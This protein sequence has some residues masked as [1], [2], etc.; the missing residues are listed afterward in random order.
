PDIVFPSF[1]IVGKLQ[2]AETMQPEL[3]RMFINFAGFL[4]VVSAMEGNPQLDIELVDTKNSR[5]ITTAFIPPQPG[6]PI[7]VQYNF[8]PT[9]LFEGGQIILSSNR[10]LAEQLVGENQTPSKRGKRGW[11]T[12]TQFTLLARPLAV[13]LQ[14]NREILVTNNILDNGSSRAEAEQAVDLILKGVELMKSLDI[15]MEHSDKQL[16]LSFDLQFQGKT[17]TP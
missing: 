3:R 7:S 12:N 2:D 13:I 5:M 8:T 17:E 11:K 14:K 9:I 1:A 6:Q 16:N 10:H 15:K 4:N